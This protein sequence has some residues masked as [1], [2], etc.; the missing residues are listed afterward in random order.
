MFGRW[1]LLRMLLG[2]S[3]FFFL[4]AF[5]FPMFLLCSPSK[6]NL[7]IHTDTGEKEYVKITKGFP[8][9]AAAAA[10]RT[11][12]SGPPSSS[13]QSLSES[14]PF[15][16]IYISG[17]GATTT[18]LS[19]QSL[20][21]RL[22]TPWYAII[23]GQAELALSQLSS[24]PSPSSPASSNSFVVYSMR[25]GYVD[26]ASHAS[27]HVY[28]PQLSA[29]MNLLACV[30]GPAIR[31]GYKKL[32]SPTEELGKFCIEM[33]MGRWDNTIARETEG[34][35]VGDSGRNGFEKLEGGGVVIG[36]GTWSRVARL[37]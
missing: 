32:W 11:L 30:L 33:A 9:A 27:I 29:T 19:S 36:N 12:P 16:F 28:I 37:G 18:P 35:K 15:H 7:K 23:K 31:T 10:F 4:S 14:Q 2:R 24:T 34:M 3:M 22:T 17:E 26:P 21:S 6:E 8:L 5:L 20:L 13:S 1:E 25:P